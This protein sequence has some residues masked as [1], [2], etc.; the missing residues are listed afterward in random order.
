MEFFNKKIIYMQNANNTNFSNLLIKKYCNKKKYKRK[1]NLIQIITELN[2]HMKEILCFKGIWK[3]KVNKFLK[4]LIKN[5]CNADI[6]PNYIRNLLKLIYQLIQSVDFFNKRNYSGIMKIGKFFKIISLFDESLSENFQFFFISIKEEYNILSESVI[7]LIC[8]ETCVLLKLILEKIKSTV[9]FTNVFLDL[10]IYII[11]LD[12]K[13]LVYGILRTFYIRCNTLPLFVDYNTIKIKK[14]INLREYFEEKVLNVYSFLINQAIDLIPAGV[15]IFLPIFI[16]LENLVERWKND[17]VLNKIT[18]NRKI[19]IETN[20]FKKNLLLIEEYKLCVDL[21]NNGLFIGYYG[22]ILYHANLDLNYSSVIFAIDNSISICDYLSTLVENKVN[23]EF[24]TKKHELLNYF[25]LFKESGYIF[26]KFFC[27]KKYRGMFI[28]LSYDFK[29]KNCTS[30]TPPW[31]MYKIF[32]KECKITP[33][34][35]RIK[36]FFQH[37]I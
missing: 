15:V 26:N 3:W 8:V 30:F 17:K 27:S 24:G 20:D 10:K 14:I 23:L 21:G 13:P 19:F 33:I 28:K 29:I 12:C 2:F 4:Y 35:K 32:E 36:T 25:V 9:L 34:L 1:F 37:I 16:S 5:S 6:S 22:G 11:L 31:E 18:K 7:N